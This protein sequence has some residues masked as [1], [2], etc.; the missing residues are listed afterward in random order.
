LRVIQD[1]TLP[2]WHKARFVVR[3]LLHL[4][5]QRRALLRVALGDL[6]C[7]PGVNVRI[8]QKRLC[9]LAVHERLNAGGGIAKRPTALAR[10]VLHR[11]LFLRRLAY[12]RPSS[13]SLHLVAREGDMALSGMGLSRASCTAYSSI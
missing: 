13:L 4:V 2:D 7:V 9:P 6:L 12:V 3:F 1:G 5:Q 8:A 11:L 10:Q